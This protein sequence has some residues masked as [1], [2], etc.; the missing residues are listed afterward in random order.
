MKLE[1]DGVGGEPR[2][3][4]NPGAMKLQPETMVIDRRQRTACRRSQSS[5]GERWPNPRLTR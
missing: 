1:P 2:I 3:G 4:R 5:P